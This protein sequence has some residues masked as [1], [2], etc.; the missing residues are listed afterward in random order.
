MAQITKRL[1]LRHEALV[2]RLEALIRHA[3]AIAARKPELAVDAETRALAEALLYQC[4]PFLSGLGALPPAAPGFSALA[5]QLGAA[6]ARLEAFELGHTRWD[7]AL[8]CVVWLASDAGGKLPVGRL[9]PQV[10][11]GA[12]REQDSA[13]KLALTR[14]IKASQASHYDMGYRAGLAAAAAGNAG[15]DDDDGDDLEADDDGAA[16]WR[17]EARV[18]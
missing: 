11:A 17:P 8:K 18:R 10:A 12:E 14:R 7:P 16:S 9:H 1:A 2:L 4:R 5:A 6:R 3:G 15:D 13:I